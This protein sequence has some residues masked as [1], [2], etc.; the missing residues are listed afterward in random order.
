VGLLLLLPR[1]GEESPAVPAHQLSGACDGIGLCL[2][3]IHL[4]HLIRREGRKIDGRDSRSS[5]TIG[6]S[7][8]LEFVPIVYDHQI[9]I[10]PIAMPK[11]AFQE[12]ALFA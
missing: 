8:G 5:E 3:P 2:L 4:W 11:Q 6:A 10:T 7:V 12:I 1:S 9:V